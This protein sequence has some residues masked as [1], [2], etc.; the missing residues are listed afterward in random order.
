MYVGSTDDG[1]AAS[2]LLWELVGNVV[3]LH[4]GRLATE[5]HVDVA[6]DGWISVRDDGPGFSIA[7][8]PTFEVTALEVAFTTLFNGGP[9]DRLQIPHIHLTPT[10]KGVGVCIVSALS[11]RTEVETTRDGTRWAMAFEQ[12][13]VASP[14]RSLGPT[15]I[16]GTLIRF[17]PDPQIFKSI[18]VDLDAVRERLQQIA[19]LNPLLRVFFKERRVSGRGGLRGWAAQ[20][21]DDAPEAQLSTEQKVD[22]VYVDIALAWS[23][24]R[25]PIIHSFVNM[26]PSREHGTHVDGLYR[27]FSDCATELGVDAA[28]FRVCVEPGLVA[29][30]HVGLY[31][32]R[33][34]NPRRDHLISPI[35]GEVVAK[36]LRDH[37]V[38]EKRLR[39][40][41][42]AR[43]QPLKPR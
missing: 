31:G 7:I 36:V 11:T 39:G 40:F 8:V 24:T 5:V 43:L 33:W 42:E 30:V 32:A 26:Q 34:G 29:V 6:E 41:F 21:A 35:A 37:L 4:L 19:W 25:A 23:G 14:L 9:P 16:E 27:A 10:L 15:S 22:D 17:R 3:D 12:G 13:N 2:H 1:S 38:R 20:L 28:A 18:D